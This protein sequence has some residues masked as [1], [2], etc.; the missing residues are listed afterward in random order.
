M[1]LCVCVKDGGR[2][3]ESWRERKRDTQQSDGSRSP[4]QAHGTVGRGADTCVVSLETYGETQVC[5][6]PHATGGP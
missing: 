4:S 5:N 6:L 2:D 3:K 1:F